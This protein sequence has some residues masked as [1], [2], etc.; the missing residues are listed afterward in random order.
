MHTGNGDGDETREERGL[1]LEM[2]L[3]PELGMKI[4][5]S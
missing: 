2:D 4:L 1:E 3:E 5:Q